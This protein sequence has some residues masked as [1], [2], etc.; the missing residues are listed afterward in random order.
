MDKDYYKILGIE[1]SASKDEVKKAFH[2]LAHKYHPDKKDGDEKKFKE[3]GEAYSVLS[4]DKKRSEYD[5]YGRVF[6]GGGNGGGSAGQGSD[7]GGFDFN[8]FGQGN[9]QGFEFDLGDV[10]GD[11]FGGRGSRVPRGR[12]I[13]IDLEI[14]FRDSVFGTQRTVLLAK[15]GVCTT[16][17]G[18]GGEPGSTTKT[19]TKCAGNGKI[20]E[21]K[22]SMFGSFSSVHVCDACHGTGK[23]PEKK[24]H[25]C[26][27]HGVVRREEEVSIAIPAGINDAEMIRLTGAGEAVAGGTTGDLYVKIHVKA[28]PVFRKEG[29]NLVMNLNVKLTDA[30]LGAT[31]KVATFDGDTEVNIPQGVAFGERLRVKGKGVPT[32]N[33]KRGDLLMLVD[34]ALPQK[35]SKKTKEVIEKLKEEGI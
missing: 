30:L 21:T 29:A 3:I 32:S 33:G 12:D 10:F 2:K 19:C 26:S 6:S 8:G 7:F 20:H 11:L 16:C 25:T 14:P 35:L 24:C 28:D 34:I 13:S 5:A 22:N 27:G 15:V 4:D 9:F 31:Y 23:V 1:R 17:T 18:T